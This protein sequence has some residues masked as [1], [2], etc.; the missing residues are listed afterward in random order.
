MKSMAEAGWDVDQGY[1]PAGLKAVQEGAMS[2]KIDSSRVE[3][4]KNQ[5]APRGLSEEA[6]AEDYE[7]HG[8]EE[9][10]E[11]SPPLTQMANTQLIATQ[12]QTTQL[13]T[14]Q[15]SRRV[16]EFLNSPTNPSP[17]SV[18]PIGGVTLEVTLDIESSDEDED[19][20]FSELWKSSPKLWLDRFEKQVN[21]LHVKSP[22]SNAFAEGLL[23]LKRTTA[24]LPRGLSLYRI[25]AVLSPLVGLGLESIE[26]LFD[27]LLGK[28]EH[29]LNDCDKTGCTALHYAVNAQ[30]SH[31]V[32]ELLPQG[33]LNIQ[34]SKDDVMPGATALHMACQIP[35]ACLLVLI[36]E[37]PGVDMEV[38]FP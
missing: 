18:A 6:N 27:I 38:K 13:A 21:S 9:E 31:A 32:E 1:G 30:W 33:C 20:S 23:E 4:P 15:E 35:D 22:M 17:S 24:T 16:P 19:I 5:G 7:K 2:P 8:A 25:I 26:T 11:M 12:I 3:T 37:A 14:T 10:E 34:T 36:L 28:L 29:T